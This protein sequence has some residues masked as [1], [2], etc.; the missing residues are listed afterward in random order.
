MFPCTFLPKY[1]YLIFD[2]TWPEV[3]S[4]PSNTLKIQKYI[5]PYFLQAKVAFQKKL[6]R[7]ETAADIKTVQLQVST[8]AT[9][10]STLENINLGNAKS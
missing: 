3:L 6:L 5:N 7:L 10:L 4:S 8:S 9:N 2:V 1:F